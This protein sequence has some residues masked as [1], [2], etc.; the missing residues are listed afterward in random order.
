MQVKHQ[1]TKVKSNTSK[2]TSTKAQAVCLPPGDPVA[3]RD[4]AP[5][6]QGSHMLAHFKAGTWFFN[7]WQ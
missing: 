1:P 7:H 6:K 5:Q 4:A 2:T 3:D